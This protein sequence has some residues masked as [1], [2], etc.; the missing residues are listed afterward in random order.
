M[1]LYSLCQLAP[2]NCVTKT[3]QLWQELS[4]KSL[5]VA[6]RGRCLLLEVIFSC[7][8]FCTILRFLAKFSL[9]SSSTTKAMVLIS[10]VAVCPHI[11]CIAKPVL[12]GTRCWH[13]VGKSMHHRGHCEWLPLQIPPNLSKTKHLLPSFSFS[14]LLTKLQLVRCPLLSVQS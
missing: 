3:N 1:P 4:V 14:S 11:A 7:L 5:T 2:Q 6:T 12:S 9:C 8:G 13:L 10:E